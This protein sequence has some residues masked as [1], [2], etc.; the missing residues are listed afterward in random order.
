[1]NPRE[2]VQALVDFR[3]ARGFREGTI[4]SQHELSVQWTSPEAH[5]WRHLDGNEQ[6]SEKGVPKH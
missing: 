2:I 6:E 3:P 1:M 5:Q 4:L